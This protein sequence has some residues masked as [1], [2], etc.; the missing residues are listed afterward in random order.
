MRQNIK[1]EKEIETI[2]EKQV[3]R[4]KMIKTFLQVVRAIVYVALGIY[5]TREY[6]TLLVVDGKIFS[7]FLGSGQL[8]DVSALYIIIGGAVACRH[9]LRTLLSVCISNPLIIP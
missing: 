4:S 7:P 2:N 6:G 9:L 1:I 5:L 8:V 3:P